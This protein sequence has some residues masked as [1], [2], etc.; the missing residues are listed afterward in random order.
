MIPYGHQSIDDAD[1][2]AVAAVLRGDWLTQGPAVEQFEDALCATTGARHAVAFANGTAALHAAAAVADLGPGDTVATS[3]LSFVASANCARYVGA[4]VTFIDIDPD[5]WNLDVRAIP[6]GVDALVAVHFAGLPIALDALNR[7]P[8]VVIEDAAHAIGA[9]TPDGPV[10]NCAH[11]DM[12]CFSF[13][14][15]KTITTGE[16]GAVTTN[17]TVYAD[18]LRRFRSHGMVR[19]P[20]FPAWWYDVPEPG[21]NYRL[22]DMQAALGTSQLAKLEAF[23]VRRN[24]LA[25]RYRTLLADAE[26][27]LPPSAPANSRHA[28]HL[29]PVLVTN[30]DEVFAGLRDA[31]IGTQVHYRPIYRH[32]T[33]ATQGFDPSSFPAC[34]YVADRILSLPLYPTLSDTDQERV[35]EVLTKLA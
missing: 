5:T 7:R 35:V 14:P 10:G 31:E 3:P 15:V 29:F 30:R 20:S 21:Y 26:V 25:S 8:R 11:S 4:D 34:E 12:T 17:S 1:I 9:L 32:S 19:S 23:V 2:A 33:Y 13:H 24:D 28:H 18:A 16:G 22:T 27:G 6:E